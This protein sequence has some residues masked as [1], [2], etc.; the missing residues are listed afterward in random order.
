VLSVLQKV[1]STFHNWKKDA[2][3]QEKSATVAVGHTLQ[4]LIK[5]PMR[6]DDVTYFMREHWSE[7][8]T[9]GGSA[10]DAWVMETA[11]Q[12]GKEVPSRN[13]DAAWKREYTKIKMNEYPGIVATTKEKQDQEYEDATSLHRG[14]VTDSPTPGA[15]LTPAQREQ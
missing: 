11:E 14:C 8:L 13:K 4:E 12:R 7:G 10:Y 15:A 3:A 5:A 1:Q 6:M 2:Q 9:I